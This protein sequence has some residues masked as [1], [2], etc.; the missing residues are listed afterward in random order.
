[1]TKL[2]AFRAAFGLVASALLAAGFVAAAV[3]P[4]YAAPVTVTQTV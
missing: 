3:A 2:P 4:A 1:M